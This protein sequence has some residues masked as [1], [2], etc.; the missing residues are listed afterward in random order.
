MANGNKVIGTNVDTVTMAKNILAV[1]SIVG[2]NTAQWYELRNLEIVEVCSA[3]NIAMDVGCAV[4]AVLSPSLRWERNFSEASRLIADHNEGIMRNY[5]AYGQNVV[6]AWRILDGEKIDNVLGGNKVKSFYRNLLLATN[7]VTIDRHAINIAVNGTKANESKSGE[8][9]ST[10]K[11]YPLFVS[12]YMLAAS[13][14]NLLPYQ[15]QAATWSYCA[16][17][18]GF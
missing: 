14:T 2:D 5:T 6:K 7:C 16:D 17:K 10:S 9:V 4:F 3:Q 13:Y 15:L 11:A 8:F 18:T 12:S 1:Y